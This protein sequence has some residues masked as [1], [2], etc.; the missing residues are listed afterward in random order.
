MTM[1]VPVLETFSDWLKASA[2]ERERGMAASLERIR[3]TD[4]TLH[5]F[6]SVRTQKPTGEGRLSGIPVGV[7]DVIETAGLPTEFGSPLYH[8]RVGPGD[9]A[10][11][12]ELRQ[13]GAVVMGKTHTAA[14]AYR[15]PGPTRNPW[16]PR[17]TPGGSSSGSAAAVA[18]GMVPCA[19][20]TQT[21]GS[22]L[23]PASYCGVTGFKPTVGLFSTDGVLQMAPSLDTLGFFTHTPADMLALWDVLEESTQALPVTV[24]GVCTSG[25]DVSPEMDRALLATAQ[26]L[27]QA[28]LSVQPVDL[29]GLMVRLG[30]A[31]RVVMVFEGARVHRAR[32]DEHGGALADLADLV[33]EGL[34]MSSGQYD[35][36]RQE[37]ARGRVEMAKRFAGTPVILMPA[38][39]GPAPEGLESTGD[40]RMNAPW[41]ALGAPAL[42]LPMPV[43]RGLPL[44]LQLV[45]DRG[46]DARVLRA[47]VMIAGLLAR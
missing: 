9:A 19:L 33:R 15:Q 1:G 8:G 47:A 45:A 43:T 42:S 34:A 25:L 46:Q 38:A 29:A 30:E 13:R 10:I 23:R 12:G 14:F 41:T 22:I 11:V 18:A 16:N 40:P 5:A 21:L 2:A 7:K 26:R 27:E 4:D 37:I 44:G 17:H 31:A 32:Y 39:T 24:L 20:G 28:G 36:A 35:E 3:E 6:V